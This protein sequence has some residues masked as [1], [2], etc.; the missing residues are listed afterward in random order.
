MGYPRAGSRRRVGATSECHGR[1]VDRTGT[2]TGVVRVCD[3]L[4]ALSLHPLAAF[5]TA[6]RRDAHTRIRLG[7]D[8]NSHP[9]RNTI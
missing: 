2:D 9:E 8:W 7:K 1:P 6:V 4:A 3:T 5:N